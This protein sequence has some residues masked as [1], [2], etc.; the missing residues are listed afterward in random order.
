[1]FF[2]IFHQNIRFGF[3]RKYDMEVILDDL[4]PKCLCLT[5]LALKEDEVQHYCL[6]SYRLV[7]S[8]CRTLSERGGGT[9]IFIQDEHCHKCKIIDISHLCLD[10]ILKC[11]AVQM[12]LK[13]QSFVVLW[14][15]RTASHLHSDVDPSIK[16]IEVLGLLSKRK[17]KI[18]LIGGLNICT[19]TKDYRLSHLTE[20]LHILNLH[21]AQTLP[22]GISCNK[23]SA[24]DGIFTNI[25][26]EIYHVGVR[27]TGI[28]DHLVISISV[29]VAKT[30]ESDMRYVRV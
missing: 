18:V 1:M 26:T 7:S 8:Y 22:T 15:Y 24:L 28:S 25:S 4:N 13:D 12:N 9:G 23:S 3:N 16:V 17:E 29:N 27:N 14:T 20:H 30:N 2:K 10:K 21:I 5:E 6:N 11:C 19:V